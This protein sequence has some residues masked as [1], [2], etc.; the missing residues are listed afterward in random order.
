VPDFLTRRHGTWHF[1]RRVPAE[2]T[3]FDR[4]GIIR[5]STKVRV[6]DDRN[7]RRAS[8]VAQKFNE[9]LESFWCSVAHG[10]QGGQ[11]SRYEAA[12]R[13]A[14]TLGFDY[15]ENDQLVASPPQK[16]LERP[17]ALVAKSVADDLTARAA[18]LGTEKRP[19]FSVSRLFDE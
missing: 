5:H 4:R 16:R 14:R 12:R 13:R 19:V 9:Q 17:E 10:L 18:L 6:A 8:R 15:I 7:G 3:A 1:F 11:L 2:F